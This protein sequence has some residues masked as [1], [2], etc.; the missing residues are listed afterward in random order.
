M[1][2]D[3]LSGGAQ[4]IHVNEDDPRLGTLLQRIITAIN[5]AARNAANSAVGEIQSPPPIG[6]I[7]VKTSGEIVHVTHTDL[8]PIQRG[9]NYF[10]E[11]DTD[12]NFP[13]PQVFHHGT[14]RQAIFTLPTM[15]DTGDTMNYYIRGYSQY[16]GSQPSTPVVYGG[17]APSAVTLSGSTQ[18]TLLPSTGSGTASGTGGQ[19]GW[20]LG[21]VLVRPPVGPKRNLNK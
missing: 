10:T 6:Q 1:K 5:K 13:S 8:A 7:N 18:L 9:I 2:Q 3:T 4:L 17:N 14:S 15:N 21:K 11:V 16:H 19:G 20:G 12:P